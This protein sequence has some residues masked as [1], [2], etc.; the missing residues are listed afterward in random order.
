MDAQLRVTPGPD[1]ARALRREDLPEA[2]GSGVLIDV[3]ATAVC[4]TDLQL[5]TGDL[6]ARTLPVIP[7]HQV[8][9]RIAEG[10]DTGRRVGLVWLAWACGECRYCRAEQENLCES[11][12]FTGWDVDGGYAQQV[13]AD[14]AFVH[15]I[16]DDLADRDDTEIA[17]LLCGGVI[18]YRALHVAGI[19]GPVVGPDPVRLGLYGF[20]A[21]ASLA[22]QVANHWG[23]RSSVVT[24]SPDEAARARELGAEWAGTYDDPLPHS[25]DA[26]ITFAPV[27]DVVV[28]ALR[29]VRRGGAVAINAIHLDRI[30]QFD[31]DD[32][33]WERSLRSV[34]NVT[35]TDAQEFLALVGPAGI[36][37][38]TEALPLDQAPQ[39]LERLAAG[40]V[41][42]SFVLVP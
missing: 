27:G 18:G 19:T 7:G 15:P 11:A 36:R 23:V 22:I 24:R 20:G 21:S 6:P 32:L 4:R 1:P 8:V 5:V 40:D 9:G 41:A 12:K 17:P 26:A 3:G 13:R 10:P 25:L 35:R 39:A 28:S 34:A 2:R 38:R 37:T 42:G 14:P 16:P 33:W 29:S 30:P 31:Y